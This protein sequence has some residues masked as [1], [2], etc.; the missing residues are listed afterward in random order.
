M[1]IWE[2]KSRADAPNVS[3]SLG[4][5][6][7]T[8]SITSP[9]KTVERPPL[10]DISLD[11]DAPSQVAQ[12]DKLL[13]ML[14]NPG[15]SRDAWEP[16]LGDDDDASV[17]VLS[18]PPPPKK[19]RPAKKAKSAQVAVTSVAQSNVPPRPRPRPRKKGRVSKS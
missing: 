8:V 13:R 7:T 15:Q 10:E 3:S 17:I 2:E 14:Q 18:G 9:E 19:P 12:R 6:D 16:S 11:Y 1:Q 5:G 4:P